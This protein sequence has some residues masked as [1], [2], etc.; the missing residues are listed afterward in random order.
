MTDY[1][2]ARRKYVELAGTNTAAGIEI[3]PIDQFSVLLGSNNQGISYGVRFL[4]N[5]LTIDYSLKPH[6]LDNIHQFNIN[7]K[8]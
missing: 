3:K 7:L 4:L 8:I 1:K 5:D 2:L 6:E